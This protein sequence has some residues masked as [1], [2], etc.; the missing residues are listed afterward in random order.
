MRG[1]DRKHF[2]CILTYFDA[3][4]HILLLS[5]YILLPI[6]ANLKTKGPMGPDSLT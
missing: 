5:M 6:H 3:L 1:R 4:N 2:Y